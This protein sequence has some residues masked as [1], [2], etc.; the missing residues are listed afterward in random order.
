MNGE[1]VYYEPS[2]IVFRE[3]TEDTRCG[4][5]FACIISDDGVV[6]FDDS[7][8]CEVQPSFLNTE[9]SKRNVYMVMY[10]RLKT[11][12]RQTDVDVWFVGDEVKQNTAALFRNENI[13]I[14]DI[15]VNDWKSL[16]AGKWVRYD[17]VDFSFA[18]ITSLFNHVIALPFTT[19]LRYSKNKNVTAEVTFKEQPEIL[20]MPVLE[21]NH[22]YGAVIVLNAK[23]ILMMDSL[24]SRKKTFQMLLEILS[25]SSK[26]NVSEWI[27]YQPNNLIRQ[28]DSVNCGILLFKNVFCLMRGIIPNRSDDLDD[29]RLWLLVTL[30]KFKT[31][32]SKQRKRML[33]ND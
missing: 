12:S 7:R 16:L 3:G 22:W 10:R 5:F 6:K 27:L 30:S 20:L 8:R 24:K 31:Q 2:A 26:I 9:S 29:I 23:V 28:T 33:N 25:K 14:N 17:I 1:P 21:R 11:E 4:H 13:E 15:D 19:F 18:Y 32:L